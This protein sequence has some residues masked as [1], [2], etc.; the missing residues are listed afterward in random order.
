M[1]L[2]F[3]KPRADLVIFEEGEPHEQDRARVIIEC[4]SQ[5]VKSTDRKEGVD[6]LKSYLA[7]CPNVAYGMWTN[8][9]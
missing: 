4:K 7:A 1:R 2:G 8:G 3:R 5:E 9:I 6:Q